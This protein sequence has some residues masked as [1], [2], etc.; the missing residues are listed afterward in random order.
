MVHALKLDSQAVAAE[1]LRWSWMVWSWLSQDCG[2]GF[3]LIN[4]LRLFTVMRCW[5]GEDQLA[6]GGRS[7]DLDCPG[8]AGRAALG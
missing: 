6:L 2:D 4:G 7:V 8:S 1:L 3:R 5:P